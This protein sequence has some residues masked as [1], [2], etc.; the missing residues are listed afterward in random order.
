MAFRANEEM[1]GG[2][3]M[4]MRKLLGRSVDADQLKKSEEVLG[5]LIDSYGPVVE[6]YPYWHPLVA[7][8]KEYES[9]VTLPGYRCGY[10]GLD[11]TVFLRSGFIT[12][13]Y[14]GGAAILKSVQLLQERDASQGIVSI[15]AEKIDAQLYHP[16]AQP[17]FVKCEWHRSLNPDGSIPT[18]LAVPLLLER[19]MAGWRSAQRAETW[20]TMAPYIL[21]RPSG[22]RSSLFV[23]EETGQALKTIWNAMIHTG[24]FGPVK[25]STW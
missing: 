15:T 25:E 3:L 14:D 24:M 4:A 22:G 19:E 10:T 7:D 2:R 12:C 16:S 6:A 23:N 5:E 20:K 1:E 17:I 8:N 9:P 21:G 11:H 18:E 13:P